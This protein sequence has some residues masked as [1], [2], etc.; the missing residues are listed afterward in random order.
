MALSSNS[1]VTTVSILSEG[2]E[3]PSTYGVLGVY[4]DK[5]INKIPTAKIRL[6]D[7]GVAIDDKF[8]VSESATFKP[9]AKITIKAGH[10]ASKVVAI[11][12]GIVVKQSLK[13]SGKGVFY[14]TVECRHAAIKLATVRKTAVYKDKKDSEIISAAW[15][16]LS[17]VKTKSVAA[18]TTKHGIV[19]Q[20][21]TTNWDFILMRADI[22]G[23]VVIPEDGKLEI[24]AP[25][26]SAKE[27]VEIELGKN[28]LEFN[29]E[30]DAR[31]QHKAATSYAWNPADQKLVE[32]KGSSTSA[33]LA[34]GWSTSTLADVTNA[35]PTMLPISSNLPSSFL[36]KWASSKLLKS[37]LALVQGTVKFLGNSDVKLGGM[38]KISGVSKKFNG[39]AYIGGI[40]HTIED[41]SWITEVRMGLSN[42]W[43]QETALNVKSAEASGIIPPLE[44]LTIGIVSKIHEDADGNFRVLLKLPILKQDNN[45]V[46]ARFTSPYAS[47]E[48]GIF[49]MPEVNDEVIVGFLNND[50]TSPIILG[51]VHSK[52]SLKPPLKPADKNPIKAIVTKKKLKITFNDEKKIIIIETPAKN[53]ITLND[54]KGLIEIIDK[55]KNKIV[56][57]SSGILMQSDKDVTIKGKNINLTATAKIAMKGTS[58]VG[59]EGMEVAIK[60]DAKFEAKGAMANIEGSATATLKGG[61]T[62][63]IKGGI[64][65]IN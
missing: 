32:A 6:R 19:I 37:T 59:I 34:G 64:V 28:M 35:D 12:E 24:K 20:Y 23:L 65:M 10:S 54:E 51:S 15:S 57:D 18:T 56:M 36:D 41:G 50:P 5:D 22:N 39:K 63:T 47:A 40:S 8:T 44:G 55:N 42:E 58:G 29:G 4:I 60:A 3:I 31:T 17:A 43:Y 26:F 48:A 7:G 14:L 11:F 21:N 13:I 27:L 49:F 30:I 53:M 62:T 61:G 38:I 1:D 33:T 46:L 2:T 25:V 52:T 16:K 45:M 9:G